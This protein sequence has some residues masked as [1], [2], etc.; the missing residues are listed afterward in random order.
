MNIFEF[1]DHFPNEE[2]CESFLK[3]IRRISA[4]I[5]RPVN[6]SQNNIGSVLESSLSAANAEEEFLLNP[7]KS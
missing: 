3:P 7:V 5:V 6:V 4:S 1:I 2:S